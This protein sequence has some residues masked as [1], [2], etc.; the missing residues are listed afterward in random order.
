MNHGGGSVSMH[1]KLPESIKA[2]LYSIKLSGSE[3]QFIKTF[4]VE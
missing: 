4:L 3:Q 1:V 2:G